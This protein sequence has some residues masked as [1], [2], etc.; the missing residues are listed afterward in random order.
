MTNSRM[1]ATKRVYAEADSSDGLR[2]L[3]D[4]LWPRGLSRERAKVDVWLK[5]IAPSTELR[6]RFGHERGRWEDFRRIYGEELAENRDAVERLRQLE[7]EAGTVT[8][9]YAAREE[10]HNNAVALRELLSEP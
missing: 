10:E 6:K 8:L 7:R 4:R 9:L 2:I 3:V 5:D 1:I